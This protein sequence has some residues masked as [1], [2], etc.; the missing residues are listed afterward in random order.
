MRSAVRF[1]GDG[2][3]KAFAGALGNDPIMSKTPVAMLD[4]ERQQMLLYAI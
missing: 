3:T 2:R 4:N 1:S